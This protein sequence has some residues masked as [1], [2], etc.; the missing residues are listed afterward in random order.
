MT[1]STK[2]ATQTAKILIRC[3]PEQKEKI[4]LNAS[5]CKK[6]VTQ[7][8]LAVALNENIKTPE[9]HKEIE[10]LLQLKADLAR[11]GNLFKLCIDQHDIN[12]EQFKDTVNNIKKISSNISLFLEK[13]LK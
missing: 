2:T 9:D 3:S 10:V 1:T 8:L 12:S 11:L 13:K 7:Y 5:M 6:N 4:F